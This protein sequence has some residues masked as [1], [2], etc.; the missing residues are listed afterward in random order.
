VPNSS[1]LNVLARSFLAGEPTVEQIVARCTHTLGKAWRW[2]PP[3]ARRYVKAFSGHTRPRH[4]DVIQFLR[5][6]SGF[7]RAQLKYR[8]ELSL[9]RWLTEPQHMQPVP[10]AT[11]W[12]IPPIE[13][14]AA[15]ADWLHLDPNDLE[16]FADLKGLGRQK[17]DPRLFH[18][19]YRVLAKRS[20]DICIIEAP[21]PRLKELQRKIL[22]QILDRIPPHP[23]VHGF[24]KSRS[25]RTF[26]APHTGQRIVLKMD[27]Q[28]FFPS[29][30][31]ARIQTIF[32]TAGYPESVADR[33]GGICTNAVPRSLWSDPALN[34][35]PLRLREARSL[36]SRPHLPQG[37]PTS[38]ALANLCAYRM[39]CRLDGL[40]RSVGAQYTR[41][42]DDLAFS[43]GK[44]LESSAIRFSIHVAAIV[45]E[46]GFCVNHRKTRIMRQGV[47]QYLAGLVI[48]QHVNVIREDVD[49]LKAT[50]TNCIRFGPESQNRNSHPH[51][52]L[53]LEGRISFVHGINPSKGMR[54]RALFDQIRW[55]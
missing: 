47:R 20:G 39:D 12:D 23:S 11:T 19:H 13:S 35:D 10:A 4:R 5:K 46:E 40:A 24:I 22:A 6:D 2:L 15:L 26:V 50:L 41:Y 27:M 34:I 16:W 55:Q 18:Y 45:H 7:N 37:A 48:N 3:L 30:R 52:R 17:I 42:A 32:R 29:I 28:D 21:K 8:D 49:L 44:L 31:A 38:P 25:I 14:I 36:Y 51:F 53:H 54:L 43:G 9:Q 1:L 33:L